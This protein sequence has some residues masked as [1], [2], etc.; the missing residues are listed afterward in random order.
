MRLRLLG[1]PSSPH[2]YD[3]SDNVLQVDLVG[4]RPQLLPEFSAVPTNLGDLWIVDRTGPKREGASVSEPAEPP[5][6]SKPTKALSAL[7]AGSE[8]GE[9][10]FHIGRRNPYA[11]VPYQELSPVWVDL[12][13]N[14]PGFPFPKKTSSVC[15]IDCVGS[16]LNVFAY[17]RKGVHIHRGAEKL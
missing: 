9:H 6:A 17:D 7:F 10:S 16:V 12:D 8:R 2:G 1:I 3:A 15:R 13:I 14:S 11:I 4:R 5:N